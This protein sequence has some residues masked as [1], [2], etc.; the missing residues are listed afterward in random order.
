MKAKHFIA[1]I[2]QRRQ[3]ARH[4]REALVIR[5]RQD[6]KAVEIEIAEL[7]RLLRELRHDLLTEAKPVKPLTPEEGQKRAKKDR[8]RQ[9]RIRD[10]QASASTR[11]ARLRAEVGS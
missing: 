8:D 4:R 11:I 6:I 9:Q 2:N 10:I 7:E 3:S 1:F 5:A